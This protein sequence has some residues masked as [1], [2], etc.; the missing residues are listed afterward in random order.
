MQTCAVSPPLC[1]LHIKYDYDVG[2]DDFE[3][4]EGDDEG[5]DGDNNRDLVS[6][7]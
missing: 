4:G 2:D 7:W 6:L 1:R 5:E 3:D